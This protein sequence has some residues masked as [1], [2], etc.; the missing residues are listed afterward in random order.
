[1]A[2]DYKVK[3]IQFDNGLEIISKVDSTNWENTNYVKL[4]DPFRLYPIPPFLSPDESTHQ[5]LILIKWL[6]WT[7]QTYI[8]ILVNKLLVVTDVTAYMKEYYESTVKK[9]IEEMV[10]RAF[11]KADDMS[12]IIENDLFMDEEDEQ[13]ASLEELTEL[14]NELAKKT[15]KVLH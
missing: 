11:N 9:T 1:M 4:Y 5:T 12:T 3:Y 8:K 10:E 7:D 2:D 14:V 13:P 15:K 6:P